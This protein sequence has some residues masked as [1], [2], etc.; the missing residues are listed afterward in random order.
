MG[1]EAWTTMKP[2]TPTSVLPVAT[3]KSGFVLVES[4]AI[5][6]A[7]GA[8]TG[9]LGEGEA[10]ARSEMLLGL[11]EDLKKKAMPHLP[12]L[13]TV[14]KWTAAQTEAAKAELPAVMAHVAKS[15]RPRRYSTAADKPGPREGTRSSSSPRT[16]SRPAASASAS[17]TRSP[18]CSPS[19]R[20]SPRSSR[21]RSSPS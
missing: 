2:T 6:R 5:L 14:A 7:V 15:A 9:A 21:R 3:L 19:P 17:S 1:M 11:N 10:F 20:P 18:S 8:Q 4:G 13:F 12:T 16:R